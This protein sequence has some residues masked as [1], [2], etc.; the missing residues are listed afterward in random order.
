MLYLAKEVIYYV[1]MPNR[2]YEPEIGVSVPNVGE[3]LWY[4]KPD[5]S[6]FGLTLRFPNDDTEPGFGCIF[7]EVDVFTRQ[8][9]DALGYLIDDDRPF[10]GWLVQ[11]VLDI[12]EWTQA[13]LSI[14]S[15]DRTAYYDPNNP[16]VRIDV[17][18]YP[19]NEGAMS[20]IYD[21][22][23]Y[24]H[25]PTEVQGIPIKNHEVFLGSVA[26]HLADLFE[27]AQHE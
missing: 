27:A 11:F 23:P 21:N 20:F 7:R 3:F 2:E 10:P 14:F 26:M 8:Q 19:N 13:Q 5:D 24:T 17:D 4:K 12:Q 6:G 16:G 18:G 1:P 15:Y 25:L 9:N 22:D